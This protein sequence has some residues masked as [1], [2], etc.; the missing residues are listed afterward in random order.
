MSYPSPIFDGKTFAVY[1]DSAGNVV[2][3]RVTEDESTI[4][5]FTPKEWA[6][7]T[8]FVERHKPCAASA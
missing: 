8:A 4:I 7:L 2:V 6:Q 5:S 3:Y 1:L